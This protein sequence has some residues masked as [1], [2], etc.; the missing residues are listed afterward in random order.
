M[1]C[2]CCCWV[3]KPVVF[4]IFESI[5]TGT[6]LKFIWLFCRRLKNNLFFILHIFWWWDWGSS[7]YL[8]SQF[9]KKFLSTKP[10]LNENV[11]WTLFHYAVRNLLNVISLIKS[12]VYYHQGWDEHYGFEWQ[13]L[14]QFSNMTT[15][16]F[17]V[18]QRKK[19][20]D[21]PDWIK[22]GS[23]NHSSSINNNNNNGKK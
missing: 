20:E 7:S 12:V 22:G 21:A 9:R 18:Q 10:K 19:M 8:F 6:S 11:F 5:I 1:S 17:F 2:C 15:K 23:K 14:W 4:K 16:D 3:D 13:C